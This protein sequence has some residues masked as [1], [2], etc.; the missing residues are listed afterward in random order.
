MTSR[1]GAPTGEG[2][3]LRVLLGLV[4]L[5]F[6]A[7]CVLA[8]TIGLGIDEAYTVATSRIWALSTFDHPPMAWWLAGG[9]AKLFGTETPLAVRFPFI[10]LSAASAWLAYD[11]GRFLFSPRAGLGA[12]LTIFLAPVLG[13]TSGSMVLPDGPLMAA[14]LAGLCCLSRAMFGDA[15]TAPRWWLLAGGAT[16]LAMLSK[17]HG[18]FL[19]AGT[20]L[21]ILTTPTHRH[22]LRS[23]WPYA[24]A[25]LAM[26]I[27]SPVLIWN[28]EHDWISFAF[29]AGRARAHR[30]DLAGPLVA[31]AGQAV[32]LLPWVWVALV[33]SLGRAAWAGPRRP[34]D[35]LLFCLAIGPIAVFSLVAL[36]G[37]KTLFHWAAPG[38]LFACLLTGRDLAGD[39][40]NRDRTARWWLGGSGAAIAMLFAAVLT[41]VHLPWPSVG[42]PNGKPA[43]Y[44][45]IETQSWHEL[46]DALSARGLSGSP[47]LFVAGLKWHETAR[48]DLALG[49]KLPVRCLCADARGYGVI[50][51]NHD[52]LGH[53]AIIVTADL[54]D[55]EAGALL[56][57]YFQSL[58]PLGTVP[59]THVGQPLQ[60]LR[61]FRGTALREPALKPN[62]VQPFSAPR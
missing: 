30:L 6:V 32:F 20:G 17:L 22:W 33:L 31:L 52:L 34:R 16:G 53:D 7:H 19:L 11:A 57:G 15:G 61:L 49:G 1:L 39:L 58:T 48:I 24:A 38:Y 46:A 21:F 28:A 4:A 10:V 41:L 26:I 35:W 59:I 5:T 51:D 29:Q 47:G 2:R 62:L 55:A 45:L 8:A 43:P 60:V 14:L 54:A 37:S 44:P 56:G 25:L 36:N 50:Y 40:A 3:A 23:R 42:L 13:W 18:A 12:A 27:F 9:A